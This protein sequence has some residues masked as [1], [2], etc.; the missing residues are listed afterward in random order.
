MLATQNPIESEGTYPL[1]EAQVDRFMLKVLVD[2]PAHDE[3]L[4]VVARSLEATP[5]LAA[6]ALARRAARRCSAGCG[7]LRR[8]GADQLDGRRRDRDAPAARPR[9]RARSPTTSRTARARAGRSASSRPGRALALIRGRDYVVPADLDALVRDAFRHRLVLSY[10]ALAEEVAPD[11]ILDAVLAAMPTPQIDLGRRTRSRVADVTAHG[12]RPVRA[13]PDAGAARAGPALDVVAA[14]ARALGRAARRRA[15]RRRLPLGVRRRRQRALAGAPVRARRRRAPHRVERDRADRRSRTFAS[16][17]R[18]ACSSRGSCS[19]RPRRWRSAPVTGARPTSP[20]ASRSPSATR[21]RGAATASGTVAF[22]AEAS[23]RAA[24]AR[25]GARCSR[26]CGSCASCP[27]GGSGSLREALELADRVTTQRALVIVVSDFRGPIDWRPPLLRLAGRHTVLAVEVRDPREQELADV[28]ELRLVDPETGRQLRV[29]TGDRRLRERF[30]AAAAAERHALQA[31]LASAGV[32]PRRA[33]DRRR[34][35]ASAGCLPAPGGTDAGELLAPDPARLAARVSRSPSARYRLVRPAPRPACRGVGAAGAAAE[36]GRAAAGV[37]AAPADRAAPARGAALAARRVRAAADD[38]SR[39]A[40]GRD[41]RP[42][43]RRLR[44]DGRAGFAADAARR[45]AK[46]P[47][48]ATSTSCRRGYRMA[49]ITF[50][51]HTTLVGAADARSD[52]R[53]R[54]DSTARDRPAGDGARRRG[55]AGRQRRAVR[56]RR[57]KGKRPPAVIVVLLRRRPDRRARHA[58]AGRAAGGERTH[59]GLCGRG[60]DARRRRAR[61][62]SRA[63]TP[64]GSR[65][66][67]SRRCCKRSR[68]RAAAA[69]SAARRPST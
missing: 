6:G 47:R 56:A 35:A 40:A 63:G 10:R 62:R 50:S 18:S 57:S 12:H 45:R 68:R 26:R 20:R 61:S 7:G 46:L 9:A 15:A 31:G 54:G 58:G 36:H 38:D 24:D 64:S 67:C 23:R 28:G 11:A 22:G 59:P 17:W 29:D 30:A 14:R 55:R 53:P 37:A 39:Q 27:P 3:E 8:P 69:S 41:R 4:T 43:A 34:L 33:V 65:S 19:T 42:R 51:D 52:A 44:L 16:S 32:A 5:E 49:V 21:R 25:A 66:R 13:D 1:P 2:Y 48:S 60:R